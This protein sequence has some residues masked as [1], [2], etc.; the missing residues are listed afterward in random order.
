MNSIRYRVH[1]CRQVQS[2]TKGQLQAVQWAPLKDAG[3]CQGRYLQYFGTLGSR[4][5]IISHRQPTG[6]NTL[7]AKGSRPHIT[8]VTKSASYILKSPQ[9]ITLHAREQEYE[10]HDLDTTW[11]RA[12]CSL[13]FAIIVHREAMQSLRLASSPVKV[14]AIGNL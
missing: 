8:Q 6:Q 5:D 2:V 13:V 4:A 9:L 3:G 7:L 14:S 11:P 12:L 1:F 10:Q